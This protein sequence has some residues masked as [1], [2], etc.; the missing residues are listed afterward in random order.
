MVWVVCRRRRTGGNALCWHSW[1][2]SNQHWYTCIRFGDSVCLQFDFVF[3]FSHSSRPSP[4][5]LL[6]RRLHYTLRQ[7]FCVE[8]FPPAVPFVLSPLPVG[9]QY[10]PIRKMTVLNIKDKV[11]NNK[12]NL[13]GLNLTEIPVKEIVSIHR[14]PGLPYARVYYHDAVAR[15]AA[16]RWRAALVKIAKFRRQYASVPH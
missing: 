9:A 15:P 6:P 11:K 3:T 2:V 5:T 4:V 13:S 16:F 7:L 1:H 10:I 12:L 8:W 14:C